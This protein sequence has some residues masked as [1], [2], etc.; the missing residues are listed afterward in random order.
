MK[1]LIE[2]VKSLLDISMLKFIIVGVINTL[3]GTAIMFTAYYVFHFSYWVSSA[4]NYI[5]ASILS[6]FL[7]KYFTFQNRDRSPKVVLRFILNIAVCYL[8]AYGAAKPLAAW[9][10]QGFGKQIQDTGAMLT[11]MCLFVVINYFGQRF[12]AFKE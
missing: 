10:L 6:Y 8:I 7:N 12:F 4:L 5:L 2:R 9:V 3:A 11:G 1:G